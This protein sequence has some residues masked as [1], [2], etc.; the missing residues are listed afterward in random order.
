MPLEGEPVDGIARLS[1]PSPS[2]SYKGGARLVH[3]RL[4]GR[5]GLA[6]HGQEGATVRDGPLGIA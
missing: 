5:V 1:G 6:H 3:E 4:H 2:E